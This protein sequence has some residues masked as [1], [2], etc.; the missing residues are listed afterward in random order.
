MPQSSPSVEVQSLD[1]AKN[2]KTEIHVK[3]EQDKGAETKEKVSH[4]LPNNK[5]GQTDK[6]PSG[7]GSALANM[8]GR[9]SAKSKP[10]N[11]AQTKSSQKN[12]AGEFLSTSIIFILN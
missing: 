1:I 9:A 12:S 3:L 4:L 2:V 6:N 10:D 5:K 7:T 8:W 11:F